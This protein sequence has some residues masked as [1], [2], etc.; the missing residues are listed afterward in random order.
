MATSP[1]NLWRETAIGLLEAFNAAAP[2][3]F[4]EIRE[5]L[6]KADDCFRFA[7]RPVRDQFEQLSEQSL[8]DRASEIE[9]RMFGD[10][11]PFVDFD[12]NGT[13]VSVVLA[14]AGVVRALDFTLWLDAE[15]IVDDDTLV[16]E[17][18]CPATKCAVVRRP[19]SRKISSAA[20]K[21]TGGLGKSYL[22]RGLL[23]HS[24]FPSEFDGVSI[25]VVLL[26]AFSI[27][28]PCLGSGTPQ[29]VVG[30][31]VFPQFAAELEFGG[32][33]ECFLV[34]NARSPLAEELVCLAI[35]K[36]RSE[37]CGIVLP[38]LVGSDELT[39]ILV[40][41]LRRA[42]TPHSVPT[43]DWVLGGSQHI[44]SH[45]VADN[46]AC[47]YDRYGDEKAKVRKAV[48][49]HD[50]VVGREGIS[51]GD[52]RLTI[53]VCESGIVAFGICKDFCDLSNRRVYSILDVDLIAVSSMGHASTIKAHEQAASD[54]ANLNEARAFVVQ[55]DDPPTTGSAVASDDCHGWVLPHCDTAEAGDGDARSEVEIT[56]KNASTTPIVPVRKSGWFT[57][58]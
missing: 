30:G 58:P 2:S 51:T 53:G 10:Q 19:N 31:V 49:Y 12:P 35:E 54:V 52:P 24:I 20:S 6:A 9:A 17:F 46:A 22:R 50:G 56:A 45:G 39:E 7:S 16:D 15:G 40:G 18:R 21:K 36:G 11:R 27:K 5:Y 28:E 8:I 37:C 4:F 1:L 48:S 14:L 44:G 42:G 41:A 55:Q 34:R 26:G 38:E 43:L 13:V 32:E 29:T 47:L 57:I 33:P 3:T 25:D 23:F